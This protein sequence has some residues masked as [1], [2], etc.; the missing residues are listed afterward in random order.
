MAKN[1]LDFNVEIGT[2][3]SEKKLPVLN[4]ITLKKNL[5]H[6]SFSKPCIE[7]NIIIQ[8]IPAVVMIQVSDITSIRL[9][10]NNIYYEQRYSAK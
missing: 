5:F 1:Y 7:V 4:S 6:S 3:I 2:R 8:N 10:T 9:P